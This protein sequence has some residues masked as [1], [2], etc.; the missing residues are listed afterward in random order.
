[1]RSGSGAARTSPCSRTSGRMSGRN[2]IAV[3]LAALGGI[4]TLAA[5]VAIYAHHVFVDRQ[6]FA[7]SV[8]KVV[9]QPAV[10]RE[11]SV[12]LSD[13]LVNGHPDLIAGQRVIEDAAT[14]VI[15]GGALDGVVRKAALELPPSF[16]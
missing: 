11:I 9:E 16:A 3:V 15:S 12:R 8:A 6:G 5:A 4:V 1:M 2:A 7:D 10:S 13:A 14:S